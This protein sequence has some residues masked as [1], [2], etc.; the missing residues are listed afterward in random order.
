VFCDESR[1]TKVLGV[2]SHSPDRRFK[3]RTTVGKIEFQGA[4]EGDRIKRVVAEFQPDLVH[5]YVNN[6]NNAIPVARILRA[7]SETTVLSCFIDNPTPELIDRLED[8]DY[9]IVNDVPPELEAYE[10]PKVV[11]MNTDVTI[12]EKSRADVMEEVLF[13]IGEEE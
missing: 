6:I 12:K 5:F 13:I 2:L 4:L 7:M 8:F 10:K 11:A 9:V 1:P 3:F